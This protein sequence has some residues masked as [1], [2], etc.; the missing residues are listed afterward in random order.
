MNFPLNRDTWYTFPEGRAWIAGEAVRIYRYG[1]CG[2]IAFPKEV[3]E[4]LARVQS[5]ID[6]NVS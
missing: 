2:D 6:F 5:Y 4:K 3:A 1:M